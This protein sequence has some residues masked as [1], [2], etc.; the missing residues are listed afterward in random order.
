MK[1]GL[2]VLQNH[3]MGKQSC[4]VEMRLVVPQVITGEDMTM[5]KACAAWDG[6]EAVLCPEE[7]SR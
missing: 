6:D 7:R 3:R 2:V 4:W 5:S 1:E